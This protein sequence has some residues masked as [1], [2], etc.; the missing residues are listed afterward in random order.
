MFSLSQHFPGLTA[1]FTLCTAP[2]K[3]APVQQQP[4][5]A[6]SCSHPGPVRINDRAQLRAA[7]HQTALH[8]P[9][10]A[11]CD[12]AAFARRAPLASL[13]TIQA[14]AAPHMIGAA[15]KRL[16]P[17]AVTTTACPIALVVTGMQLAIS[18]P[19]VTSKVAA[20]AAHNRR[21]RCY[22]S[23]SPANEG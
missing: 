7:H 23:L 10:R 18:Q 1:T 2:P 15:A 14:T 3:Q 22:T 21:G 13:P 12:V 6:G 16:T 4:H 19:T 20:A 17:H 5:G 8:M 11:A 9:G